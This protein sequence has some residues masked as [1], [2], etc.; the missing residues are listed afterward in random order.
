MSSNCTK[1]RELSQEVNYVIH[2][3]SIM[4]LSV[5]FIG[6]LFNILNITVLLKVKSLNESPYT[7][8]TNLAISDMITLINALLNYIIRKSNL[9]S[10]NN[11]YMFNVFY[12]IPVNNI[13]LNC[14]MYLTLAVTSEYFKTL[15]KL[16]DEIKPIYLKSLKL[17]FILI[18]IDFIIIVFTI[19]I[20]M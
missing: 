9:F 13:V 8:L 14:S 12:L 2:I 11:M 4:E 10:P 6:I 7:Y 1:L 19:K 17:C 16:T 5:V 15:K 3:I 18:M 20:H